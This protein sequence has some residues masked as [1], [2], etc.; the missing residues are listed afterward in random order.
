[1]AEKPSYEELEQRVKKIEGKTSKLAHVEEELKRKNIELNFF[2]NNIPD[3]AWVKDVDSRF[4]AVNRAFGEAVGIFHSGG[5]FQHALI[6]LVRILIFLFP[7][8]SRPRPSSVLSH[9]ALVRTRCPR[10]WQ[11]ICWIV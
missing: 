7:L 1:M 6:R 8:P 11:I 5:L 4:I 3:M 9:A 2:I 10:G